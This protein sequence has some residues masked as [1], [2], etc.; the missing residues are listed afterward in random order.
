MTKNVANS[1]SPDYGGLGSDYIQIFDPVFTGLIVRAN[2]SSERNFSL[3]VMSEL[4]QRQQTAADRET[5]TET[6]RTVLK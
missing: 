1:R 3:S 4:K 2:L 6:G 5:E